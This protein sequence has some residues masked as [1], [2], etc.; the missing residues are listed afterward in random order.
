VQNT[1]VSGKHKASFALRAIKGLGRRM[2]N[3]VLKKAQIDL[4]KRAGE[5]NEAEIN[6]INDIISRPLDYNIPKWF[7]NR[8]KDVRDGTWSH[9]ISNAWDT[10]LREDLERMKK[11][12][13]HRGLRHYWGIKVKGQH[14][15][16]T[17]RRGRTLGVVRKK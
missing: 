9:L 15:N 5:L 4:T 11:M 13:M 7:L 12:R 8:Q 17:G 10:K 14:T 1:N 16:S 6:K 3:L 2:T